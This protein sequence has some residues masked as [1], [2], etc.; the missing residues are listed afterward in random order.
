M[1]E[2]SDFLVIG[3]GIVGLATAQALLEKFPDRKVIV[4]EKESAPAQH[5]TGHNSG[6]I[7]SGIYYKPGSMKAENCRKGKMLLEAFCKAEH[8]PYKICGKIILA[9][10]PQELPALNALFERGKA[11]DV[12]SKLIDPAEIH[13]LEPHVSGIKAIHVEDAGIVDFKTV[14][15]K[16]V[17]KIA[18]RGG[19]VVL[20]A[21]VL[22][23][24]EVENGV[25]LKTSSGAFRA[26]LV[27]NCAGLHSDS[28]AKLS[29][30]QPPVQIVPF[31]GEYFKLAEPAKL[32]CQNLIYPVPNPEFPFLGVHFT[33][34]INGAVECGPNAVPAFARE[35]YCKSDI[36]FSDLAEMAF[37]S[38]FL[39]LGKMYWREGL[40]EFRR[41]FSKSQFL[42]SL[43]RLIPEIRIEHL[44][45]APAG[46]RAQAVAPDGKMLDDFLIY[47]TRHIIHVLNAPSPAATASLNIGNVLAQKAKNRT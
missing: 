25:L 3:A 45:S 18:A 26:T 16:L 22:A 41:S 34:M 28:V 43:Q 39:K 20:N 19:Q 1:A 7:H 30:F 42:K 12:K 11:N 38:G 44:E 40:A 21:K 8:I 13:L 24:S 23:I 35:G 17:E 31:R 14:C 27:L 5:Q 15:Q 10:E 32:F 2:T 46:V 4:L 37:Y 6:V 33:R 29:G 9:T 36:N 47:E